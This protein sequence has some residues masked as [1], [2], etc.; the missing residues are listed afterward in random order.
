[1]PTGLDLLKDPWL[2][3]ED[4]WMIVRTSPHPILSD[5]ILFLT[6]YETSEHGL[7]VGFDITS[8]LG[9]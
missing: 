6:V 8:T 1:M 3:D 7:G 5:E 9:R 4:D 2:F